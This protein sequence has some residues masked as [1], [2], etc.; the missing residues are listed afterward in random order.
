M[1]FP[2][3]L[4]S[5]KQKMIE[6]MRRGKRVARVLMFHDVYTDASGVPHADVAVSL[7]SF[8]A[9]IDTIPPERVGRAEQ[10]SE[11]ALILTFDDICES[12]FLNAFPVLRERNMPY[13]VF[14]AP[15]LLDQP[16]YLKTEQLKELVRDPLC[17]VGAHTVHHQALRFLPEKQA[18]EEL[19]ESKKQLEELCGREVCC[20]AYPYGSIYACSKRNVKQAKE[21]GFAYAFS[22]I[23]DSIRE[24]DMKKPW[25][26]P[27]ININD[28]V[29]KKGGVLG[30]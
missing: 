26:L 29:V 21:A 1:K 18:M 7:E 4:Y 8:V 19:L 11:G 14:I 15:G 22:T 25:F 6:R 27:R 9:L 23:G 17:T 20:F 28:T 3:K 5:L 13:T 24:K 16:G 10:I 2:T 30:E 12:A